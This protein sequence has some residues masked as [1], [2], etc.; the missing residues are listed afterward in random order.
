MLEARRDAP[1]NNRPPVRIFL[2]SEPAQVRAERVFVWSIERVRDP[3][4]RYEIYVMKDL[5]GFRARGWTTGFTQYR[6]AIPHF[7]GGPAGRSTT[8]R[9]R[10][11]AAIRVCSSTPSSA[12]AATAA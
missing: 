5:V 12:R 7:A 10:S 9:T 6:F 3:G 4:R 1:A 8:T 2:G 11:T